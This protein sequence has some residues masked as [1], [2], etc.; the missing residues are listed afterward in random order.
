MFKNVEAYMIKKKE[1]E[2]KES[3]AGVF[4]PRQSGQSEASKKKKRKKMF[5]SYTKTPFSP[6]FSK[7]L[8]R[9]TSLPFATVNARGGNCRCWFQTTEKERKK[10]V[11]RSSEVSSVLSSDG[12]FQE[13]FGAHAP[14][15]DTLICPPWRNKWT[16]CAVPVRWGT[17]WIEER[18]S[19][20]E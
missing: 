8:S 4:P 17:W 13:V 12:E 7:N 19:N 2:K 3:T 10:Q 1:K 18:D 11:S 20:S 16:L 9:M 15:D 14:T 6:R 5:C